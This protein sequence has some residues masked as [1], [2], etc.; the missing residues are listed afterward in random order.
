MPNIH[1]KL[2]SWFSDAAY[3]FARHRY[4]TVVICLAFTAALALFIPNLRFDTSTEGFFHPGDPAIEDYNRFREQFGR[5]DVVMIAIATE[6]LFSTT[7]LTR[8][9]RLHHDLESGLPH[10]DDLT[11]LLNVR[12]VRGE[13][14][15][16]IVGDLVEKIPATAAGMERLRQRALANPFYRDFIVSADGRLTTIIIKLDTYDGTLLD[17]D[18]VL[19]GFEDESDAAAGSEAS[20]GGSPRYLSDNQVTEFIKQLEKIVA[21][22]HLPDFQISV[23]GTPVV[24]N[25][26]KRLVV[27]DTGLFATLST[28][29]IAVLLFLMF[30]RLTGVVLP[31]P[32]LFCRL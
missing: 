8:L 6:D 22:H 30:R 19:A 27:R 25:A 10:V 12:Q 4:K 15:K 14:E 18:T 24:D 20:D 28:L 5:D 1:Q 32:S 7:A 29:L 9:K 17:G 23:A 3:L 11:S 31:W 26:L 2:E 21:V 13:A 16:L